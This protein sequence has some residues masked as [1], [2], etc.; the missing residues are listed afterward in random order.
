[1]SGRIVSLRENIER[2]D[3][4][5]V[6]LVAAAKA[7]AGAISSV[8]RHI[9]RLY[10]EK[11]NADAPSLSHEKHRILTNPEP[12]TMEIAGRRLEQELSCAESLIRSKMAG[13]IELS[14]VLILL[15]ATSQTLQTGTARR[16]TTLDEIQG[17]LKRA[18]MVDDIEQF[19]AEVRNHIAYLNRHIEEMRE[20]N[21]QLLEDLQREM[22]TYRRQLDQASTDA[23]RDPLTGL[24]NRRYLELQLAELV[25]SKIP[26]CL[27]LLDF[28]R[29]KQ[30]NDQ[31]GHL[32]GDEL[33]RAFASR[34]ANQVREDDL[35]V[36]WGGDE[37]IL[38]LPVSL[39]DALS[40]AKLL[41]RHLSG[42]YRLQLGDQRFRVNLTFTIAVAEHKSG[43]TVEQV[44]ARA[45]TLLY[46][47]KGV[48]A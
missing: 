46:S 13:S 31:Y 4:L 27:V 25:A 21:R 43:E 39:P 40:R 23:N 33:L 48:P 35:A 29:F 10:P 11:L 12:E 28:N 17:G 41:E 1:M 14:E 30:V 18:V 8:E 38:M 6:R 15:T 36:R 7:L 2:L 32:A 37:F 20:E 22:H 44:I 34:L 45:D 3:R 26:F 16:E 19:R 5:D 42:D 47:R 9:F 24:S